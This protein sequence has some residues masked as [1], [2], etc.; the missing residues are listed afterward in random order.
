MVDL[1]LKLT[2]RK[3]SRKRWWIN[4]KHRFRVDVVCRQRVAAQG[5][6]SDFRGWSPGLGPRCAM[7]GGR[8]RNCNK[9]QVRSYRWAEL[10]TA[11]YLVEHHAHVS[12]R[13]GQR[14]NP[15]RP[16]A[17]AGRTR[18]LG[19]LHAPG[20]GTMS[21]RVAALTRSLRGSTRQI[22]RGKKLL[23]PLCQP[24]LDARTDCNLHRAICSTP[25]GFGL[26]R[27]HIHRYCRNG[28]S[29]C[30]FRDSA[31]DLSGPGVGVHA[32]AWPVRHYRQPALSVARGA[33]PG[34]ARWRG[35]IA[36]NPL[37]RVGASSV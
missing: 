13:A 17:G 12:S 27:R 20:R 24:E 9:R 30:G 35:P 16:H 19:T 37:N 26:F 14:H 25:C 32:S 28:H 34:G 3:R 6:A 10:C 7:D 8:N 5:S 15:G 33:Q 4:S 18:G 29:Q 23:T 36:R 22:R 11:L 21:H 31:S 1:W 2:R